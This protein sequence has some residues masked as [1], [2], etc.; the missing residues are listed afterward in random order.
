[1]MSNQFFNSI[2]S[3]KQ[4]QS[5]GGGNGSGGTNQLSLSSG[6]SGLNLNVSSGG[7]QQGLNQASGLSA[8]QFVPSFQNQLPG[9][10]NAALAAAVATSG[11]TAASLLNQ[12]NAANNSTQN[13]NK[14]YATIL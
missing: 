12:L 9:F 11:S 1:M 7:N 5:G 14:Q 4:N 3:N 2:E 13:F 10:Q 6:M 8:S